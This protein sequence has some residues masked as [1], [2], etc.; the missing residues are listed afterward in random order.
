MKIN[1]YYA[2]GKSDMSKIKMKNPTAIL[3]G[4]RI[5][6]TRLMVGFES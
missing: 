4:Q 3:I 1:F 2:I 5:K 6:Q